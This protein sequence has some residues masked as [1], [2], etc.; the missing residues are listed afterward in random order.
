MRC[1]RCGHS[2]LKVTDSRETD[3]GIRRRRECLRCGQRFTTYERLQVSTLFVVKKDGRRE[4][5]SRE[6]L[7]AGLRKACEKRPL[8]AGTVDSVATEIESALAARGVPEVPTSEVGEM[9]MSAL[10]ALDPVAYVRFASVYRELDLG[11]LVQEVTRLAE[12]PAAASGPGQLPL[13]DARSVQPGGR[14]R[15]QPRAGGRGR[16]GNAPEQPA[17]LPIEGAAKGP[18]RRT[19]RRAGR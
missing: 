14:R 6:K 19:R 9:V 4:E 10:R 13:F 16:A 8:P 5:F 17:P 3:D 12:E 7:L 18:E 11:G 2:E 1:P 15:A